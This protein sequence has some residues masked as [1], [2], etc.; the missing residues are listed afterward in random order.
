MKCAIVALFAGGT[1][2]LLGASPGDPKTIDFATLRTIVSVSEPQVAPDGKSVVFIKTTSDYAK[3]RRDSQLML[4][5]IA[6]GA[7]RQLTYSRKG[8]DSPRWSPSGDRLAFIANDGDGD[9]AQS[10]IFVMPMDGGD[11]K[12]V[13]KASNGV[14]EFAW[15]PDGKTLAFVTQDDAPDKK[16]VDKHFDA[17]DVGDLDYK[18]ESE[19]VPSH[20][21]LV[22][23]MGGQA[24]RLTSGSW[25]ISTVNG[26]A[27][28][29]ISWSA[30]G[31][32][33]AIMKLPDAV[34]GDSDAADIALVD[35][36][37]GAVRDLPQQRRY[38]ASPLFAPAGD[39]LAAVWF[40]H[41]AFNSNGYLIVTKASGGAGAV[42]GGQQDNIG[43]FQWS[44]DR[45]SL[46]F[47][48][49]DG[50]VTRLRYATL[51]GQE[52]TVDLGG[53][54]FAGDAMV[55]DRGDLAFI[56]DTPAEPGE[57]YYLASPSAHLR[58]L[59]H[60][61]AA[62]GKLAL[63][64]EYELRWTGPGAYREDGIV[65]LPPGYVPGRRYPLALVVHGGPQ[66][67]SELSF[68]S[69]TQLIAARGIVTFQPNYRGSTNLGDAYQH[70]IY[71]DTGDGPGKDVMAGVAELE[72]QGLVD[73]SRMCV[74]GW[75]YG[76]YMTTWLESHYDVWK[77][78]MAGAALTS[79]MADYTIS[80]YQQGDADFFGQGSSPWNAQGAIWWDQSPLAS[81]RNVKAPT[82][83]M[84]DVGDPNV[85]IYNSY[86][87]YHALR[88]DGVDVQ[89]YAY[90]RN[91]H[92]PADPVGDESVTRRWVDWVA[93][94]LIGRP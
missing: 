55:G 90:P 81:V 64:K 69:L 20:I 78:A 80:F 23:A 72:K 11:A 63:G 39:A 53:V 26:G 79:W 19:A 88:D 31:K 9:D 93:S 32:T 6:T 70:A 40:P 50:P 62:F 66:S 2:F 28:A 36:K 15:R 46:F 75:S 74:T 22:P 3:D 10:Q 12:Q 8:L 82:L 77:C 30:D 86:L 83:I 29:P 37:S 57:V 21:W 5:D 42:V 14:Q 68:D 87:W 17:F 1:L 65:T 67:A 51:G 58:T 4:V 41:G 25:S 54:N 16:Q 35:A 71:R 18:A 49:Q 85:P 43:W 56:G 7:V 92:Y 76:G 47:A 48:N 61:N 33:I 89:F 27:G 59:T 60:Y 52:R 44:A 91:T 84:G 34:Y 73:P 13:T 38:L 45:R 94:H 24:R